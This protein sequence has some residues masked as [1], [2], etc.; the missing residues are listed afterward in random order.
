[1]LVVIFLSFTLQLIDLKA[2]LFRKQEEFKRQKLASQNASFIKGKS[3]TAEKK[4]DLIS[5]LALIKSK[6]N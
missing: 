5:K 2:E 4:V 6:Q 3:S 1:M